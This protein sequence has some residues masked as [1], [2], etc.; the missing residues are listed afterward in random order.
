[1]EGHVNAEPQADGVRSLTNELVVVAQW[2]GA[3]L[4][5]DDLPVLEP[6]KRQH[7]LRGGAVGEVGNGVTNTDLVV[8]KQNAVGF[9][10][11]GTGAGKGHDVTF[12][13]HGPAHV[14]VKFAIIVDDGVQFFFVSGFEG[15]FVR[16]K[17]AHG[18]RSTSQH[19]TTSPHRP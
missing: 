7:G 2:R 10:A 12:G 18:F 17:D 4:D 13:H 16:C 14:G 19:I 3:R 5:V 15:C 6:V 11:N 9:G 1:M 8:L